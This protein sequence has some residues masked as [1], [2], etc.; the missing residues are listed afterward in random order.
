MY[1]RW[2]RD[3]PI[4]YIEKMKGTDKDLAAHF[5]VT[6]KRGIVLYGKDIEDVFEMYHMKHI[7]TV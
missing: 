6:K 7:L 2:Y 1:L 3:N 5:V 4:E